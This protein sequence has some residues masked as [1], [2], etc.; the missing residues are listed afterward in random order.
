VKPTSIAELRVASECEPVT[1][2]RGSAPTAECLARWRTPAPEEETSAEAEVPAEAEAEEA[3]VSTVQLLDES[4]A[5]PLV[6]AALA[7]YA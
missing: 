4:S 2:M 7:L 6:L 3:Q 5:A 1:E